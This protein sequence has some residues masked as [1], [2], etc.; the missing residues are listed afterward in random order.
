MR[1]IAFFTGAA[2]AA[3]VAAPASAA[4]TINLVPIAGTLDPAH[5]AFEREQG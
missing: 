3:L 5:A 2:A 4:T 1:K